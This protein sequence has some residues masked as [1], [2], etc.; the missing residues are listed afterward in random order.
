M[1]RI[2]D[3]SAFHD[4]F[5]IW[6]LTVDCVDGYLKCVE[7]ERIPSSL[8]TYQTSD[9]RLYS[10]YREAVEASVREETLVRYRSKANTSS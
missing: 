9:D 8:H 7:Y 2:V 5:L 3:T 6:L 4:L 10:G 1:P